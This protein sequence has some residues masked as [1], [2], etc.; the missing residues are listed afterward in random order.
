MKKAKLIITAIAII[1]ILGLIAGPAFA[2]SN[3]PVTAHVDRDALTTDDVLTLTVAVDMAAGA[4]QAPQLGALDGF[5]LTSTSTGSMTSIVNGSVSRYTNFNYVLQP[6]QPGDLVIDPISVV[7]NGVTYFTNPITVTVTQGNGRPTHPS[8][9]SSPFSGLP[10]FQNFPSLGNLPSFGNLGNL[11]N[12]FANPPASTG[13]QGQTM[14]VDPAPVPEALVGQ[15]FYLESEVDKTTPYQGQQLT[16]TLRF[17]Q[18][19]ETMGQAEYEMPS[20]TGFWNEI[21]QDRG[22]YYIQNAG[23]NYR[24]TELYAILFPTIVGET[25]IER[26]TMH[27][28][29]DLFS[30]DGTIQTEPIIVNVRPLP[31]GAPLGFQG[32]VG[33][34]TIDASI[35]NPT[36]QV[37]DTVTWQVEIA[38]EGNIDTLPDPIW[39]DSQQWRAFDDPPI[40]ERQ[41]V[42][43][44]V[45]GHRQYQRVLVPTVAGDLT[46][47][48]IDYSYFDPQAEEYVTIRS[49]PLQVMVT[50]NGSTSSGQPATQPATADPFNSNFGA[51][52][53]Q[54]LKDAPAKWQ[55]AGEPLVRRAG[56]WLLWALPVLALV[57]HWGWQQRQNRKLRNKTVMRS[58]KAAKKAQRALAEIKKRP[59]DVQKSASQILLTY[60]TE[61]FNRPVTG[62]THHELS[63]LLETEG[64]STEIA[65]KTV[66][67][68]EDCEMG[69]YS[70]SD[71]PGKENDTLAQV[72]GVIDDLESEL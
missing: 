60:L 50:G 51:E 35:D 9:P 22:E 33:Q 53:L 37:N 40:I 63:N 36:V 61:R 41:L 5:K 4:T 56:F 62:L 45:V 26:A 57:G 15:D 28:P 6:N 25:N 32:A 2:Q 8:Q 1:L 3:S 11:A 67:C 39:P 12:L 59:E 42:D 72:A 29:S 52:G 55:L 47:P 44:R 66:R 64:V 34:F 38:G 21:Q 46:I 30:T 10:G 24:V 70:P 43:G 13:Q 58:Q 17:Y 31:E 19:V 65:Q 48:A 49:Q 16:Y 54:P 68:L 69:R 20:F 18:A 27:I 23:R 71:Y 7:V 14:S